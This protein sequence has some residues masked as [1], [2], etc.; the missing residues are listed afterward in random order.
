MCHLVSKNRTWIWLSHL[1]HHQLIKKY[2]EQRTISTCAMV[3]K[4][5]IQNGNNSSIQNNKKKDEGRKITIW[6]FE[7][8]VIMNP[9]ITYLPKITY[10]TNNSIYNTWLEFIWKFPTWAD[11]ATLRAINHLTKTQ[12]PCTR[13][14]LWVVDHSYTRLSKHNLLMLPLAAFQR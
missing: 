6:I 1:I 13:I 7:K 5:E 11:N 10:N 4:W 8:K 3:Y 2:R 9:I 12:T 14:P